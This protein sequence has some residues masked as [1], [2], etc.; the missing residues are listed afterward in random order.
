[1]GGKELVKYTGSA[2]GLW[3]T[4]GPCRKW[5]DSL[6]LLPSRPGL[7]ETKGTEGGVGSGRMQGPAFCSLLLGRHAVPWPLFLCMIVL[8]RAELRRSGPFGI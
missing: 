5:T 3:P 7:G 2:L 1:M 8:F 6:Q 4:Q